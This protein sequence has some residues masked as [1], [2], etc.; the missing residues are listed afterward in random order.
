MTEQ[1]TCI[2]NQYYIPTKE[3]GIGSG[4]NP[5]LY[6]L[7]GSLHIIKENNTGFGLKYQTISRD[8]INNSN[9]NPIPEKK[10]FEFKLT[11][12]NIDRY[13][14]VHKDYRQERPD[15][16][17]H[18]R[19]RFAPTK[20]TLFQGHQGKYY[21]VNGKKYDEHFPYEWATN[22]LSHPSKHI[23]TGPL[24]CENCRKYGSILTVF[25]G[26]CM[27]CHTHIYKGARPGITDALKT[28]ITEFWVCLPY[29]KDVRFINIGDRKGWTLLKE[30]EQRK[31]EEEER[32]CENREFERSQI[33]IRNDLLVR[34]YRK[35]HIEE[36]EWKDYW[37]STPVTNSDLLRWATSEYLYKC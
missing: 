9:P 21:I 27:D 29:M 30:R 25:V 26:Y 23:G 14:N 34:S 19:H 5:F 35:E 15:M 7:P 3:N 36:E 37:S 2:A 10:P 16:L 18:F 32:E 33:H 12:S 22:H 6:H 1:T 8:E 20:P 11:T 13:I 28:T 24:N 4:A 17:M 31:L